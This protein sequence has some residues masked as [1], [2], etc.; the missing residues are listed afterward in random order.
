M[1]TKPI[2]CMDIGQFPI[3]KVCPTNPNLLMKN[4]V[5]SYRI[6][7]FR[8]ITNSKFF[9]KKPQII[10]KFTVVHINV[11]LRLPSSFPWNGCLDMLMLPYQLRVS[12]EQWRCVYKGSK[13][14]SFSLIF[15]FKKLYKVIYILVLLKLSMSYCWILR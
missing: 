12:N 1:S 8:Q 9:L 6:N 7:V 2:G 14:I 4:H 11:T 5:K 13:I 3:W 10:V 15:I